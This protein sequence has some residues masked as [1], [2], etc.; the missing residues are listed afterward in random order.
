VTPPVPMNE[1]AGLAALAL[2]A[3]L[4]QC[5]F[6]DPA[7]AGA[8]LAEGVGRLLGSAIAARGSASLAVSGGRSPI[9]FL[10]ALSEQPLDWSRVSVT[11]V[12][13]RWVDPGSADSNE[14]LVHEHLLRGPAAGARWV[15]LK[16]VES[17]P[18]AGLVAAQARLRAMPWPLD[19][20]VLGM[21]DDGHTASLFPGA[22]GLAAAL[23]P[24][25]TAWL[26]AIDPPGA[27][28]ARLS[29]T[30]AALRQAR[31]VFI[32]IAG[33][34]KRRVIEQAARSGDPAVWPIAGVLGGTGAA[35]VAGAAGGVGRVSGPVTL[36]WSAD[37]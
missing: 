2:D 4:E 13:E 21:G 3:A 12:D 9:A 32:L 10:R 5:R 15:P 37:V 31:Q 7:T 11:L 16:G 34:A 28:H 30:L 1:Q 35:G 19:A 36:Y 18:A 33:A 26:A 14:A 23:D 24:H 22:P 17:S 20:V 8:A 6:T 29:L 25:G 27:P